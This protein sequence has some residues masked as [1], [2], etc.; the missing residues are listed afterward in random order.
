[1]LRRMGVAVE[2]GPTAEG[3]RVRLTEPPAHLRPL[4]L[5]V[6]GDFSSAAFFIAFGLLG[7][8]GD[9]L[10][11]GNVGLN[12]ARTGLLDVL[13]EM[14][15][16]IAV[17]NRREFDDPAGEPAGDLLV[18]RSELQ[19]TSVGGEII[20]RLIDEVPVLAVVATHAAGVTEIRDALELRLKESDR[21][22]VMARNLE[23]IGARVDEL[24]DGLRISGGAP[25]LEG[26]VASHRDHR[27]AM[28]FGIL[29]ALPRQRVTVDDPQA[30]AVSF[31]RFWER[32][33][34]L[35]ERA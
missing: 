8:A 34:E 9:G 15:A 32:L 11:I 4:D 1:M 26:R 6:P 19:G 35:G 12:P 30:A 27:I 20:P 28:A 31:P 14:G 24:P 18:R 13:R 7:G 22:R 29:G 25:A 16:D 33:A 3:W 2:E 10:R 5:R 21:I 23:G 17:E